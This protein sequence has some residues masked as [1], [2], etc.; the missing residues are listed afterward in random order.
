MFCE[1]WWW[2]KAHD[3]YWVNDLRFPSVYLECADNLPIIARYTYFLYCWFDLS[4]WLDSW[5]L[6]TAL[7][8]TNKLKSLSYISRWFT[9]LIFFIHK[10]RFDKKTFTKYYESYQII[11][12]FLKN[13]SRV[14]ILYETKS[15]YLLWWN[16]GHH[17]MWRTRYLKRR[18]VLIL[19]LGG[20]FIFFLS[21]KLSK[22]SCIVSQF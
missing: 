14:N 12:D 19:L 20:G 17:T 11:F 21:S 4:S 22:V 8:F 5:V 10:K 3:T 13:K 7:L 2:N 15:T 16:D 6:T 18:I 1:V 9:Y